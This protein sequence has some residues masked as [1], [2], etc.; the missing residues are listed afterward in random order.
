MLCSAKGYKTH[1][2]LPSDSSAEKVELLTKLGAIVERVKPASIV[3]KGQFVNLAR[4][5]AEGVRGAWFA[6]QFE[7]EENWRGHARGTGPEI[8]RQCGGRLDAFVSGAG[9]ILLSCCRSSLY[10]P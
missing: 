8:Y 10:C 7:N 5:R 3:D 2:L 4:R 1:I 9:T 6:D